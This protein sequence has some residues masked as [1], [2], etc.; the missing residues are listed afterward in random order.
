[1]LKPIMQESWSYIKNSGDSIQ[2]TKN[3]GKILEGA[4]LVSAD[5]VGL[6]PNIPHGARLEALRKRLNEREVPRLPTEALVKIADFLPKNNFFEFK[7]EVKRQKPGTVIGNKFETPYASI[8]VD[9]VETEFCTSQYLQCFLWLCYIEYIFF[10]WT[11]GEE[12]LVQF[13]NEL[14]NFH[15]NLSFTYETS[16]NNLSFLDLNVR[17]RDGGIHVDIY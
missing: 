6:Y 9:A 15:P 7:G 8:F 11:H 2:T 14:N 1:M 17:L 3:I 4:I 16:K 12:K 5:V 13:L 10:I